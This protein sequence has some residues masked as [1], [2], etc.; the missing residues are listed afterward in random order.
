MYQNTNLD[1]WCCGVVVVV[2]GG[3]A[4]F[5]GIGDTAVGGVIIPTVAFLFLSKTGCCGQA[6]GDKL[7][8]LGI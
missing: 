4:P 1:S 5:V 3:G 7:T 6:T 2:I 8:L